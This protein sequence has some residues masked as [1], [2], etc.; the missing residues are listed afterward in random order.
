MALKFKHHLLAQF[1]V[2]KIFLHFIEFICSMTQ[3]MII[4]ELEK[5][6]LADSNAIAIPNTEK[7]I[8]WI[9]HT[10]SYFL[11]IFEIPILHF[12]ILHG[13]TAKKKY[14]CVLG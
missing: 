10:F 11:C 5:S 12:N 8:S 9:W 6:T 3:T 4:K 13:Y 2:F 14:Q 7:Q 1:H